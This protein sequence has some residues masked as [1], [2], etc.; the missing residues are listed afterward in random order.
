MPKQQN[1]TFNLI[2]PSHAFLEHRKFIDQ[3]IEN[4]CHIEWM[5]LHQVGNQHSLL[6]VISGAWEHIAKIE[7]QIKQYQKNQNICLSVQRDQ[8]QSLDHQGCFAYELEI[9]AAP[10]QDVGILLCDYFHK[11][12][13]HIVS[14]LNQ[15]QHN[16]FGTPVRLIT[17]RL[18]IPS[19]A[20]FMLLHE[21]INEVLDDHQL[22]GEFR[23][24]R[25]F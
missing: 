14:H 16:Q 13:I 17:F 7:L 18:A 20:D 19:E 3:M 4:N 9:L 15:L 21:E 10:Q 6:M 22:D 8:H 25:G 12:D 23:M 2:A 24:V 5:Q 11:Q 1:L